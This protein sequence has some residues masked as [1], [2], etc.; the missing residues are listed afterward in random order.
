MDKI[1]FVILGITA[2]VAPLNHAYAADANINKSEN[3]LANESKSELAKALIDG[4]VLFDTRYRFE[5]VDQD[6]LANKANAHTL[7]TRLGYETLKFHDFSA[8]LEVEGITDFGS[9]NY[10]NTINGKTT[11]PAVNDISGSHLNRAVLSY[12]GIPQ[13]NI[14][15]GRQVLALDN[16]RWVGPG[17]WRQDDQTFDAVSITNTSI[18]DTSL[19]YAHANQVNRTLG[20]RSPVGVW[21]NSDINLFNASYSSLKAGKITAY[22]YMIDVPDSKISSTKTFGTRFEG[23]QAV[24]GKI[25]ALYALE[26][27]RQSDYADNAGNFNLNYFSVEPSINIGQWTI[28]TQYESIEGNGTNAVQFPLATLHPFDGWADKLTTTPVNGLIDANV[29]IIYVAKSDNV[30]LNGTKAQLFHHDYSAE[31]GVSN[32]YGTEWNASLEQTINSHYTLGI[33]YADYRADK[34]FTDTLKIMPYIQVKF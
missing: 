26:Y 28:K 14:N 7:R 15:L 10:N 9:D 6:G 4:K 11:Y 2:I 32:H 18:P 33:Q 24:N 29:G 30:Y 13:T 17:A 20:E 25:N 31:H 22:N 16:M 27:A 3:K 19:F 34:L 12:S 5:Y 23:K 1:F 8:L 21:N